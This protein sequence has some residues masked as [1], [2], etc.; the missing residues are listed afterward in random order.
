[1]KSSRDKD[2]G[3]P[4]AWFAIYWLGALAWLLVWKGAAYP[5]AVIVRKYLGMAE[6]TASL[7][8]WAGAAGSAALAI[9]WLSY[10]LL[11]KRRVKAWLESMTCVVKTCLARKS[12]S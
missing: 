6:P 4:A 5:E 10:F 1:M 3:V 8:W 11:R 12:L 2:Q 7:T 9:V